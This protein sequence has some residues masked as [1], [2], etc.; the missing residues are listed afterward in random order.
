MGIEKTKIFASKEEIEEIS[1]LAKEAR[2]T[3][4]IAM[5]SEDAV[6]G[7]DLASLTWD[8]A[9]NK[10]NEVAFKHGLPKLT[11]NYGL[12]NDGEFVVLRND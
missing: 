10:V 6:N 12:T 11:T 9:I 5:N 7:R 4:M 8:K 3:P 1:E 2:T